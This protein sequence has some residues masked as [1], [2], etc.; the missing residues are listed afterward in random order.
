MIHLRG[1]RRLLVLLVAGAVTLAACG[2]SGS[3]DSSATPSGGDAAT[4]PEGS[5]V[6]KMAFNANMQV[7]DPDIFYEV[8]G[9]EVTTSVYEGLV[10]YK[11]DSP[12][13]EPALA[14]SWTISDDGKTYTF[15]LRDGVKFHDGTPMDADS[16]IAS[17]KRRTD[18]NSAPA[19][20][21]ADVE[22]TTAPDPLTFVVKL[23]TVVSPFLHYLAL[24][25][26][27]K[28]VSPTVLKEKAGS[29]FAQN[30]LKDHDAGTGPY[31]ITKFTTDVGYELTR[32]DD[33]WDEKPYFEKLEIS[34]IPD[35]ATQR[36]KLEN[37]EIDLM[38]H[39][40]PVADVESFKS[41]DKFQVLE[42]PVLLK[43]VLATNQ[44]K[45][46]FQ[47][48]KMGQALRTFFDKQAIVDEVYKGQAKLSTQMYPVQNLPEGMGADT[49]EYDPNPFTEAARTASSKDIDFAYSEDE[50]GTLPRL[51]EIL[52]SKLQEAGFSVKVRGMP[53]A[54]VFE[55][56]ND[57]ENGPDLLL[58]TFNPDGAHPDTWGRIFMH[59][60]GAI[61]YLKC[62]V[63]EADAAMD[64]GLTSLKQEDVDKYYG[65]AGDALSA[66][67]CWIT[68][69][70]V[71]EIVVAR[72]GLTG[73]VHQLPT[74][75]TIRL[76][77][78]KEG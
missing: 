59:S 34:I 27:P 54:Q 11:P 62:S 36:L 20:M 8:E 57:P 65:E 10:R 29:D 50:G 37:G 35:I 77:D 67:G 55:L 39:G 64:K 19:Y 56:P 24:P 60:D 5:R 45:G 68:F 22:S 9:N 21:L 63:P 30:Y 40:L 78:L 74:A 44:T 52:A 26:G 13:I 48:K 32:F 15:K 47:D 42:F 4:S 6:L 46:I 3:D 43:T 16:W 69:A 76:K 72:K 66:S 14:E 1:H 51:A 7:P 58:W 33:Y 49:T 28:A 70:D 41:N 25:Y 18:V 61:N 53:I 12:E 71:T 38:T 73:F 31:T 75:Y 23:K 17:F 2:S